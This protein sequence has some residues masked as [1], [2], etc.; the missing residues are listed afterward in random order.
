[1]KSDCSRGSVLRSLPC[2]AVLA[3]IAL[4]APVHV[5][6]AAGTEGGIALAIVY[7]TSGSMEA[8]APDGAGESRP[9]HLM[10]ARALG[11]IVDRLQAYV[12][13]AP[14]NAPRRL[15]FGLFVFDRELNTQI[16][17]ILERKVLL[18]DEEPPAS[19]G[20]GAR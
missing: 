2:G 19:G 10:A 12:T 5:G 14:A 9:K 11:V 18:E 8:S 16:E 6:E 20:A 15:Q 7:D 3:A 4:A 13:N 1:M 17:F